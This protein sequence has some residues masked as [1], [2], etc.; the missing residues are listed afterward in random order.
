MNRFLLILLF[1]LMLPYTIF[2]R[3]NDSIIITKYYSDTLGFEPF[4]YLSFLDSISPKKSFIRWEYNRAGDSGALAEP[5]M[6]DGRYLGFMRVVAPNI[7]TYYIA[8]QK[9]NGKIKTFYT[10]KGINK[11]IGEIDNQY[12]AYFWLFFC[13]GNVIPNSPSYA[14]YKKT[15][16]GFLIR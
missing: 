16:D 11:F 9:K 2:C 4:L 1:L 3:S 7:Y 10:L 6:K 5:P 15:K 13:K 14:T 12:N 8:A